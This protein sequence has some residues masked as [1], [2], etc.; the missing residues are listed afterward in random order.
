[1]KVDAFEDQCE[2]GRF[3]VEVGGAG[4]DLSREAEAAALQALGDQH[5]A[6]AIPEENL[7]LMTSLADEAE[8]VSRERLKSHGGE[9]GASERVDASP[10]IH[11]CRR[12]VDA[13]RRR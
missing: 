13:N 1:M 8:D 3:E 2:L 11:G 7:D 9:H 6:G 10:P 4:C 5:E 12:K